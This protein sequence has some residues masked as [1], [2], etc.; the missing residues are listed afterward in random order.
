MPAI[1]NTEF[2]PWVNVPAPVNAV[3]IVKVLA[4]VYEPVK[5]AFGIEVMVVPL[6]VLLVPLKV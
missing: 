5:A 2:V 4:L 6:N 1:F 3:V